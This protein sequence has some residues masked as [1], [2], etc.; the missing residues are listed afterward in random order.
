MFFRSKGFGSTKDLGS[1]A[2]DACM[3][4][5]LGGGSER[6]RDVEVWARELYL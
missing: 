6:A 4:G 3:P 2:L 1:W 5:G